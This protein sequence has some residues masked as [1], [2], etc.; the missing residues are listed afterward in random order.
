MALFSALVIL[1]AAPAARALSTQRLVRS[2]TSGAG[3]LF[4]SPVCHAAVPGG[5]NNDDGHAAVPGG[6]NNDDGGSD[7]TASSVGKFTP[8]GNLFQNPLP[9]PTG[10]RVDEI[11]D[12][13]TLLQFKIVGLNDATFVTDME[14]L[15]SD[16]SGHTVT[17]AMT[18][19]N[20]KYRSVSVDVIVDT[21]E[22]F[23]EIYETVGKDKRVKFM[24]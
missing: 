3:R 18:R 17:A 13:P 7:N 16:T 20:G 6:V 12:F 2:L 1:H 22:K 21:A 15:C 9:A 5:V 4:V 10:K 23:Y 24:I 8:G 11:V 14:R 19:D